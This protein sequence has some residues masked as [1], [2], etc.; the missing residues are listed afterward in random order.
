[1]NEKAASDM[2]LLSPER[3]LGEKLKFNGELFTIVGVV[4]N[5]QS[6][7]LKEQIT[8]HVFVYDPGHFQTAAIRIE[9]GQVHRALDDFGAAWKTAFPDNYFSYTFLSEDIRS[10]YG[11]EDKFTHL[12][13][14][15]AII[16][17]LI[18][19][20]GLYGLVSLVCLQ[21]IREIGVRKVLGA[22]TANILTMLTWDFLKL[23][24][25]AFLIAV[26]L[27][28]YITHHF[29]QDYAYRIEINWLIFL[30]AFGFSALVSIVTV[31][32]RAVRA[33]F[34]NP[35]SNLKTE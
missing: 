32:L 34:A 7:S 15:L 22:T 13:T 18:G 33:S 30:L 26:P 3:S 35:I 28:Y 4:K 25:I 20:L 17:I 16:G 5:F 21:K 10:F 24:V 23:V 19:C 1:V 12:L 2:G 9:P 31:S 14:L 11:T 27:G 6:Q 29:L 8:P